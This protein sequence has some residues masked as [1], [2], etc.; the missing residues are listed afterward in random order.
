MAQALSYYS[1]RI[2]IGLEPAIVTVASLRVTR[3]GRFDT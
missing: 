2:S 1:S 3:G